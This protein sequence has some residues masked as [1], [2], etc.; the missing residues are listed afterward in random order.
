MDYRPTKLAAAARMFAVAWLFVW[1]AA[2]TMC[3]HQCAALTFGKNGGR[4]CCAK[5]S[6][7]SPKAAGGGGSA[8]CVGLKSVKFESKTGMSGVSAVMLPPSLPVFVLTL[9]YL[10]ADS[11]LADHVRALP[12]A[13]FVF[14]PEVS[15]GAAL[16]SHAPPALA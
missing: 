13:D 6:S 7:D 14:R 10:P 4:E 15:L 8:F 9:P 12:R 1:L 16:R 3:V 2:Q 11:A 5:K